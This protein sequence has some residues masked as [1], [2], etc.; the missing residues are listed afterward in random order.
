[1]RTL[2]RS[3]KSEFEKVGTMSPFIGFVGEP[4]DEV[5]FAMTGN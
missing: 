5:G 2:R 4:E 3:R 1:M